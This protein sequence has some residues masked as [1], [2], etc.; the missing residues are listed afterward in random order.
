MPFHPEGKDRFEKCP[1]WKAGLPAF[2]PI[3]RVVEK[4]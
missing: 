3:K 4:K 1:S 2:V